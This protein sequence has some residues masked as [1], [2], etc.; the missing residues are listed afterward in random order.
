MLGLTQSQSRPLGDIDGFIQS[1]PGTYKSNKPNKIT[2]IDK[3]HLDCE[4]ISNSIVNSIR[5][6]L[7]YNF[8]RVIKYFKNQES[9]FLKR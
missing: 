8:V 5:E 1:N 3:I 4:C 2:G 9:N 7:S 6:P